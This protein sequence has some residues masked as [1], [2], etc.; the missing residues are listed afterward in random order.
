MLRKSI[1]NV[2]ERKA[3]WDSIHLRSIDTLKQVTR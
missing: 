2:L 1:R 3:D